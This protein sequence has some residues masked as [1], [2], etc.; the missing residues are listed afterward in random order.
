MRV[1]HI[2][3]TLDQGGAEKLL[4][5]L[6][7]KD[8][9]ND[10]HVVELVQGSEVF[11]QGI[12]DRCISLGLPRNKVVFVLRLPE[13][14]VRLARLIRQMQPD[15]VVGWLYY[16]ALLSCI[17]AVF[18]TSVVWSIHA[19]DVR[20]FPWRVRAVAKL[21]AWL[22]RIIPAAVHFCSFEGLAAHRRVGFG[23][24]RAMVIHNGVEIGASSASPAVLNF[25]RRQGQK[26][27]VL[28]CIARFDPQKDH[29]TLFGA[30]ALLASE[31][32]HF[33]LVLAGKGCSWENPSFVNLVERF[34]M[35]DR[36]TAL[37]FVT[38]VDL[39]YPALDCVVLSSIS[40]SM[41]L[42]LLE[43]LAAGK[44][45]V[46]TDVGASRSIVGPFGLLVQPR[47]ARAFARA[48]AEVVWGNSKIASRAGLEAPAYIARNFS[49]EGCLA[50]WMAM[51]DDVVRSRSEHPTEA[52][53]NQARV[54]VARSSE[55]YPLD[56]PV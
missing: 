49:F 28:G 35:R 26:G 27:P 18:R 14:V 20:S 17:G 1:V 33:H 44:P 43:A 42:C 54:S 21:C 24:D 46:A 25:E 32:K 6:V 16:G 23:T 52:L 13:T 11:A 4:T 48:V 10:Q 30:M 9:K 15:V 45:V 8:P 55:R 31:G 29:E 37:G 47:D 12:R 53:D 38:N 51:L 40:E 50:G 34:K 7:R 22:S 3:P 19:N 41:P 5:E 39:L 2:I 56:R 36:V